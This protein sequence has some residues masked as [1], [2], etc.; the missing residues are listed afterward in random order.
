MSAQGAFT[1]V[2]H[3]HHPYMRLSG[4]WYH[5]EE[6]IHE[7]ILETY[8]PLL[9]TLYDLMQDGV[10]FRLTLGL[11]PILAEQLADPLV[12]DH[13][14][15]YLDERIAAAQDDMRYFEKDAYNEHLRYLAE[16]Y[17][18]NLQRLKAAFTER[19]ER[20][21]IGAF[22]RLQDEGLLEI[23]TTAATHAYLPLLSRD[24][25]LNGQIKTAIASYR[26]LF[27]REPPG[28]WLPEYGYRPAQVS[29]T[30]EQRPGIEQALADNEISSF[31]ADSHTL[32][33]GT[34]VGIAAGNVIGRYGAVKRRYVLPN[35]AYF[36]ESRR[37]INL[38]APHYADNSNVAVIARSDRLGQQVW[39]SKLGYPLDFDYRDPNRRAGTSGLA[40]WRITGEK[41]DAANKDDYHPDWAS[42]KVEQHAEHFAH[43]VGDQLRSYNH[44]N[45]AYGVV[46]ASFDAD[47]FGHW[48]FE[49][50]VW[51]GKVLRHLTNNPDVDLT[52]TSAFLAQHPPT[53]TVDLRESSWGIGGLH[54]L[55]DNQENHWM[56]SAIHDAEDRMER[57][58]DHFTAPTDAESTVLAQA[59]RELLLLQSADWLLLVTTDE[60]RAYAIRR[61]S[62]HAERFDRL[63]ASLE[64]G[65]PDADAAELYY[66]RDN[67]FADVDYHWFSERKD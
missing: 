5:T 27:G 45:G 3:A 11:S 24:S 61:F 41:V 9:E 23:I 46:A 22:K 29:E 7:A 53:D 26:R 12:L 40:Y 59:A 50:I 62:E 35:S 10:S 63:A 67:V 49:G 39:G 66:R 34:P 65:Q 31:F 17:R 28:F 38:F 51:L 42:Y 1:L 47:L 20:S 6:W 14:A 30:G 19:F 64:S 43:L 60:G 58:A 21:L 18:D 36:P 15:R 44:A 16:W 57:L 25:S 8:L 32:T 4:R 55:W 37:E 33:G 48:W 2:L 56:W 13:F 54:F 52:T